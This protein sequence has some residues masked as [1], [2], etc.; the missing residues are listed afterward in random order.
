MENWKRFEILIAI[1]S[2]KVMLDAVESWMSD[3]MLGELCDDISRDYDVTI[4]DYEDY[5]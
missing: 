5:E 2:E 1:L 3:D 4:E